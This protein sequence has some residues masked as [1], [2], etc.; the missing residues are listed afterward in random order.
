[1]L[2]GS[3]LKLLAETVNATIQKAMAHESLSA[4]AN[5]LARALADVGATT[6][7]AWANENADEA[8]ANAVPYMQA[9]GHMVLAWMWL[10]VACSVLDKDAALSDVQ[11]VGRMNAA[12]YF[13]HYE[14]PKI[15]AWLGVVKSRDMTCAAVSADMF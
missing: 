14:L 4:Y 11:N 12:R 2:G 15:G 1:M 6:K 8:L 5:Q 10:D 7:A 9:F 3:G 13:F